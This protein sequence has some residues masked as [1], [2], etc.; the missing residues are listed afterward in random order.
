V[1]ADCA[2]A[3]RR[4]G[5]CA[6]RVL[7]LERREGLA[8]A[9]RN[10]NVDGQCDVIRGTRQMARSA[11]LAGTTTCQLHLERVVNTVPVNIGFTT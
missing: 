10:V 6:D 3:S 4:C 8:A 9:V 11:Q 1:S 2:C 7:V 5:V